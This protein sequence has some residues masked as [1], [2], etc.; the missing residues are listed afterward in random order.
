MFTVSVETHFWA[1]HQLT[2]SDGP[3]ESLHRHNWKVAAEVGSETLNKMGLVMDFRRLKTLV[4]NIVGEL[5]D[6]TLEKKDYFRQNG[7]SAEIVAKYIYEKL[8]PRLPEAVILNNIRV[9]EEPG[10][11]AKFGK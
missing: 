3:K 11:W 6:T 5:A 9:V 8:S 1:S 7:S 4:D 10:C 2:L